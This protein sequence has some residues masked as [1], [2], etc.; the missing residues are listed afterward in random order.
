MEWARI[1]HFYNGFYVYK[2]AT[3]FAAAQYLAGKILAGEEGAVGKY[4]AFLQ[5]GSLED[6]N[7]LLKKAG[8]DLTARE[9]IPGIFALFRE[10]LQELGE[11][12]KK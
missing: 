8:V 10:R 3:S 4:L 5:S 12:L 1:P 7:E 9:T 11:I 6:P 2:Y